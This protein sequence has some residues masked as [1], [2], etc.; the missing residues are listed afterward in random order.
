MNNSRI[1]RST[2]PRDLELALGIRA[3]QAEKAEAGE[4]DALRLR[5]A[6][7]LAAPTEMG[8]HAL[9]QLA[10]WTKWFVSMLLA[11]GVSLYA[12]LQFGGS[13]RPPT[14]PALHRPSAAPSPAPLPVAPQPT[15]ASAQV[16]EPPQPTAAMP[17]ARQY[18]R[19][20]SPPP[21]AATLQADPKAEL[22]LLAEAQRALE[23]DPRTALSRTE[24]HAELYPQG[25]FVQE[26]EMI[27]I[28]ALLKLKQRNAALTR[29][30]DF[31]ARYPTSPHA[32]QLRPLLPVTNPTAADHP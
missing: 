3:L 13:S 16:P 9:P 14:T 2:D 23:R 31:L 11:F 7:Q 18:P 25:L 19:R 6:Q 30:A 24:R 5:L 12:A 21:K 1:G 8:T 20:T 32:R 10:P 4:I 17:P 26:R 22:E 28:R 29:A 27:A 15:I